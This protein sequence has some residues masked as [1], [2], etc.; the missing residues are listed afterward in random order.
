MIPMIFSEVRV[1]AVAAG[2]W[3]RRTGPA[4]VAVSTELPA[5]AATPAAADN[6]ARAR[7]VLVEAARSI[8]D[9]NSQS[10][11]ALEQLFG[12]PAQIELERP[13]RQK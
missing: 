8:T 11:S 1:T 7:Q 12:K 5:P 9:L 10:S 13:R 6:V 3:P 4:S 2:V